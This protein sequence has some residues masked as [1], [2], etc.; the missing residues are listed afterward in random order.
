[1]PPKKYKTNT[2]KKKIS[3]IKSRSK[4]RAETR[5][6]LEKVV[7]KYKQHIEASKHDPTIARNDIPPIDIPEKFIPPVSSNPS[8]PP[9]YISYS[10]ISPLNSTEYSPHTNKDYVQPM[11]VS[12]FKTVLPYGVPSLTAE[13]LIDNE[14][15]TINR[16]YKGGKKKR[17]T[18][19]KIYKMKGGN[20]NLNLENL[21]EKLIENNINIESINSWGVKEG[22]KPLKKLLNE[23]NNGES[24]LR[25]DP[26][27]NIIKRYVKTVKIMIMSDPSFSHVLKEIEHQDQYGNT[28]KHRDTFLMEKFLDNE[29][30]FDVSIRAIKEELGEKYSYNIRGHDG[31]GSRFTPYNLETRTLCQEDNLNNCIEKN[32]TDSYSFPGLP[33]VNEYY[34]FVG[35][36]PDLYN[37]TKLNSFVTTEYNNDNSFK[38]KILWK[39]VPTQK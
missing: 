14:L 16:E 30:P 33:M 28:T 11:P 39:W 24:T 31:K 8:T 35:I 25:I 1:M 32:E 22:T 15:L 12:I 18:R 37:E 7:E 10:D 23:I 3:D 13:E 26:S 5:K 20:G 29:N 9:H 17:K 21:K 6:L 2:V 36:I 27:D 19:K 38:R 34:H 4:K